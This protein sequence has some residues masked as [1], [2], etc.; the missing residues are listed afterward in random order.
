MSVLEERFAHWVAGVELGPASERF[1]A[2]R[3]AAESVAKSLKLGNVLDV[4]AY[5]MGRES[6]SAF[7][8]VRDA[9][10]ENDPTFAAVAADL[11]PRLVASAA[12]A[13]ILEA[14]DTRAAVAA[15]AVLSAEFAGLRS[16]VEELPEL[17]RATL[18]DRFNA[19]RD[20]VAVPGSKLE[21]VFKDVP[22]FADE[23]ATPRQEVGLFVS[24]VKTLAERFTTMLGTLGQRFET[25][26]DATDEELDVLWWAFGGRSVDLNTRWDEL[27]ASE[28]LL[29][30][31][32]E[33]ANRHRFEAEIPSARE[34]LRR[35]LGPS[36]AEEYSVAEVVSGAAERVKLDT[37]TP[38]PLLPILTSYAEYL[39]FEG[40][41]GWEN[42][43][44]RYSVDPTIR[45]R[46]DEIAAQTMRELL[47]VRA[48]EP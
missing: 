28:A 17:S 16:P 33:I 35:V 6:D 36:G 44:G 18:V 7:E 32:L 48:L 24:A 29:R 10:T 3:E 37:V 26:L 47:L 30:S 12:L 41:G 19:L 25:R 5:A 8:T 39:A 13:G 40:K 42:S 43:A 22:E 1:T 11:E 4:V 15:G 27:A 34:I 31:G 46:G 21:S 45:R 23:A 38:G 9:V 14:E 20:R 2:L